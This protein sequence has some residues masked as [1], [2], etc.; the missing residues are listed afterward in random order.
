MKITDLKVVKTDTDKLKAYVSITFDNFLVVKDIKIIEG[1][2]GL[3]LSM[4]SKKDKNGK[5]RDIVHPINKPAR[6][7]I[8]KAIFDEYNKVTDSL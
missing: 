4:P 2:N 6:T 5:Y 3:F 1:P 8:E 7:E